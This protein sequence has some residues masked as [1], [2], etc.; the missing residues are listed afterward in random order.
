MRCPCCRLLQP[1]AYDTVTGVTARVCAKCTNHQG[2]TD[3]M[4]IRR[5][6]THEQLLREKLTACRDSESKAQA[7]VTRARSATAQAREATAAALQ[8]RGRLAARI[9]EA[10]GRAGNHACPLQEIAY[11]QQVRKWARREGEDDTGFFR[12]GR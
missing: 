1:Q 6:E 2:E 8:S 4:R 11:D 3:T 12:S 9:V 7:E 5:A 10:A